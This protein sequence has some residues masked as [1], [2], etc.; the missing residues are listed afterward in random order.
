MRGRYQGVQNGV[1]EILLLTRRDLVVDFSGD[2]CMEGG[3]RQFL[4]QQT[5][6]DTVIQAHVGYS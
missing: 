4:T 1:E 5:G 2:D 6:P 3:Y